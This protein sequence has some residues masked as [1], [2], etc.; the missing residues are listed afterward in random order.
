MN[1][2]PPGRLRRPG[3][4][5][6]AAPVFLHL[7][8]PAAAFAHRPAARKNHP[9]PREILAAITTFI[10]FSGI[11]SSLKSIKWLFWGMVLLG[12]FNLLTVWGEYA[13][14][15]VEAALAHYIGL[16]LFFLVMTVVILRQTSRETSVNPNVIYGAV[17][18]YLLIAYIWGLLFATLFLLDPLFR[19]LALPL[20]APVFR[21]AFWYLSF[22]TITP[23][24][25]YTEIAPATDLAKSLAVIEAV[26]GQLYLV[27]QISYWWVCGSQWWRPGAGK[28]LTAHGV[29][30]RG[31][32]VRICCGGREFVKKSGRAH[33][34]RLSRNPWFFSCV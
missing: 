22:F 12:V 19:N 29:L 4:F 5:S 3:R 34:R 30:A 8:G 11:F 21:G 23:T 33:A 16:I 25:G 9:L 18:V 20:N 14:W 27:L 1:K 31:R 13:A 10:L 7:R 2:I 17:T 24:L 26:V 32:L 6:A 28:S 15:S